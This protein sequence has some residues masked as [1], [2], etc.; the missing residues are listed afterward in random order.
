MEKVRWVQLHRLSAVLANG[1][2]EFD[3]VDNEN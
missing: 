2:V 3:R 1:H